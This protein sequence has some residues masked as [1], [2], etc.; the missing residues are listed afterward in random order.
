MNITSG[1][2][3]P[4][5]YNLSLNMRQCHTNPNFSKQEQ[6]HFVLQE[7]LVLKKLW[8]SVIGPSLAKSETIYTLK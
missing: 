8:G 7:K 5:I 3:L 4:N 1:M 2:F 6:V